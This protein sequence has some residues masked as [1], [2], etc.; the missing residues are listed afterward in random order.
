MATIIKMSH[1]KVTVEFSM[2]EW[3]TMIRALKHGPGAIDADELQ[4]LL[5][6]ISPSPAV[7]LHP[8]SSGKPRTVK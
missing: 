7:S 1:L 3:N 6:S 2:D 8:S 4:V 5:K